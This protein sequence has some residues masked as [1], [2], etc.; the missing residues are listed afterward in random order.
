MN[1]NTRQYI[2]MV[3]T[4]D[5]E[6]YELKIALL[7][8]KVN[9]EILLQLIRSLSLIK[10]GTGYGEISIQIRNG[11]IGLIKATENIALDIPIV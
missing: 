4:L 10:N 3:K 2:E 9:H 7:E 5:P 8:T 1:D 6:L 11:S